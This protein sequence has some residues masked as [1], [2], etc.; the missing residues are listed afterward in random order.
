MPP[1]AILGQEGDQPTRALDVHRVVDAPL[2]APGT[3]QARSLQ[4]CEVVRQGRRRQPDSPRDLACRQAGGPF[5][6]EKAK[7]F[8]PVLLS[9]RGEGSNGSADFHISTILERTWL[10]NRAEPPA[11]GL[12]L[13]LRDDSIRAV[14]NQVRGLPAPVV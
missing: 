2:D 4:D 12:E 13:L 1:T 10:V 8:Q 7:D 11:G 14:A 6:D 5:L 3:Q 9:K